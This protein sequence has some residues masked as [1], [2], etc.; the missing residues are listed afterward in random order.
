MTLPSTEPDIPGLGS[1]RR[2][3][4]FAVTIL[5]RPVPVEEDVALVMEL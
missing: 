5:T 3:C 4:L 2:K 1:F